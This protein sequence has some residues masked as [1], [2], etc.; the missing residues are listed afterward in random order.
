M[1]Y[2]NKLLKILL[3]T[4]GSIVIIILTI[5]IL[6]YIPLNSHS[7]STEKEFY[8]ANNGT[9]IDIIL[10]EEGSYKAYGWG[11]EVF[12]TKVD[13]WDDMSN[14]I[15]LQALFTK[16]KSLMRVIDHTRI[17]SS[18]VKVNCSKKQYDIVKKSIDESFNYNNSPR[19]L[20]GAK[21]Y[22]GYGNYN[23]LYTC[24]TWV[25]N[26]LNDADLKCCAY[27][28]TSNAITDLYER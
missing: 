3:I 25:N 20:Y 9:H 14:S 6:H 8:L 13:N 27:S 7:T 2:L 23:A 11:S 5:S 17:N 4:V 12:Y 10:C 24:N 19:K 22:K 28:L 18:W 21:F 1:K 16:P 15:A 26:I